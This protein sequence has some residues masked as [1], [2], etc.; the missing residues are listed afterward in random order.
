MTTTTEITKEITTKT[1]ITE[2]T[3]EITTTTETTI[4]TEE[5]EEAPT[6]DDDL[7]L[8]DAKVNLNL[9]QVGRNSSNIS[10]FLADNKP[11]EI[12]TVF[13]QEKSEK[14]NGPR[15]NDEGRGLND[16]GRG[17]NDEGQGLNGEVQGQQL[18]THFYLEAY[19]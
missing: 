16:E 2:T 4:R 6:F 3:T 19:K 18:Y 12:I 17:L 13:I 9:G 14:N 8:A 5:E 10:T 15:R 11:A 1:T 7:V